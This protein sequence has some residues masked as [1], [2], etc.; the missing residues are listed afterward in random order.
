MSKR[1]YEWRSAL[2]VLGI[3]LLTLV[4]TEASAIDLSQAMDNIS[5]KLSDQRLSWHDVVE[6]LYGTPLRMHYADLDPTAQYRLRVTYS[7]RYNATMTLTADGS[8]EIHAALPL[9]RPVW[10]VEFSIPKAATADGL[11]DLEWNLVSGRGCQV[12]EVWLIRE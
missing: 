10:P 9:P 11:L 2:A 4:P 5:H 6:T 12:G 3:W 1:F 8:H 7:G